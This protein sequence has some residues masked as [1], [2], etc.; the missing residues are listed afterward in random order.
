M[1]KRYYENTFESKSENEY[2]LDENLLR[3]KIYLFLNQLKDEFVPEHKDLSVYTGCSGIAL[4]LIKLADI[5]LVQ[6]DRYLR[7]ADDIMQK[8]WKNLNRMRPVSFLCGQTGPETIRVLIN[9]RLKTEYIEYLHSIKDHSRIILD[10]N[11]SSDDLPDEI[12]YGRSGY[13]YAL[14]LIREEIEDS[15]QIIT[16]QLIRSVVKRILQSGQTAASKLSNKSIE[17]P[18]IY[19]WHQK[20][21]VGS[22]HGYAGILTMVL[23]AHDYLDEEEKTNLIIP[24][25]DFVLEQKFPK[26]GNYRSS[27][28]SNED[29]L[30]HWC[31][32]S[33]GVIHLLILAYRTFKQ[34]KYLNAARQASD[35]I[36]SRGMLKKGN[37]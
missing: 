9:Y 36:W 14:L 10:P 18:L 24:A 6:R 30:V 20:G 4:L 11:I 32:G 21:Y 15:R 37:H 27:L 13:L 3:E 29:R 31:H 19:F 16:D 7:W 12:L 35:D 33:P 5:Q 25:I 34:E 28:N 2:L 22:A 8:N 1:E 23:E 26:T 17:S